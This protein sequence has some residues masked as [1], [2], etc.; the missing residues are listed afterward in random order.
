MRK[1]GT[2]LA[3]TV[4]A[5][6]G[7]VVLSGTAS[8]TPPNIPS[9]A[10]A[11]S[12]L[13]DAARRGRRLL[14]RVLARQVP[15]LEHGLR[16]VQHPGDRA[17]AGRHRRGDRLVVR[18]DVGQLVQPVRR[19]HLVRGVR[20]GH[21]PR[22][23]AGERLAHRRVVVDDGPAQAFANDLSNPQLI[24]VTDNVNQSK[25]DQTPGDVEAAAHRVL[26]HLREDVGTREVPV[27]ADGQLVGEVRA[28]QHARQ[29]LR[30]CLRTPRDRL[31]P[32]RS[33]VRPPSIVGTLPYTRAFHSELP[34]GIDRVT[35]VAHSRV[36]FQRDQSHGGDFTW[37]AGRGKCGL[38]VPR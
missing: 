27:L 13:A 18:R 14:E 3:T 24:A 31:V 29:L 6:A 15:A 9:E 36:T 19:R 20:C 17:Q 23:P 1:F 16:R 11:R 2:L 26:V 35:F 21:R 28:H 22:G 34:I 37:S 10:T 38:S 4:L 30:A 8:A 5:L 33:A 7:T 25:G 32:G 12:E